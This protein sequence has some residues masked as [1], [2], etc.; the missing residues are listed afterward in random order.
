MPPDPLGPLR[1]G[2]GSQSSWERGEHVQLPSR[3]C[4]KECFA[5]ILVVSEK[6][7]HAICFPSRTW[8]SKDISVAFY[9]EKK[10]DIVEEFLLTPKQI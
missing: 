6:Q 10:V 8:L 1:G 4:L 2:L 3:K 5:E 7:N 9:Q